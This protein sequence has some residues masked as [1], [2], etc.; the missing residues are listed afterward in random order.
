MADWSQCL[1][2]TLARSI[3]PG[4]CWKASMLGSIDPSLPHANRPED[5]QTDS[6][7]GGQM[8]RWLDAI[9]K[10]SRITGIGAILAGV[11]LV[12]DV[13]ARQANKWTDR[14]TG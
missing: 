4:M 11:S 9:S 1:L 3:L 14:R 8:D 7:T 5:R 2:R 12:K 13:T 6:L 10:S